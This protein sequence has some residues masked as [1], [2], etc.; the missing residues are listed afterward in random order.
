MRYRIETSIAISCI[1]IVTIACT[2]TRTP[3]ED[4]TCRPARP[5]VQGATP[6][7]P[8]AFATA[9]VT[10]E[11]AA[12]RT[13]LTGRIGRV[14][15]ASPSFHR[16]VE[17]G[18]ILTE[19]FAVDALDTDRWRVWQQDPETTTIDVRD[20]RLDITA[21]GP[22]GH[23]GL[24]GLTYTRLRDVVLVADMDIRS[25][26]PASHHIVLHLCGGGTPQGPDHWIEIVMADEGA[27]A[28]FS[29]A[30]A[31]PHE[32]PGPAWDT[33]VILPHPEHHGFLARITFDASQSTATLEVS[34]GARWYA[35]GD[36]VEI[37]FRVIHTEVKVH[38]Y[39]DPGDGSSPGVSAAWF[40][41]VRIYPRPDRHAIG[42]RL[43]RPDGTPLTPEWPPRFRDPA[44][45]EER[46]VGDL[47][48]QLLMEDGATVIA[49]SRSD[50]F[51]F[52][53]LPLR[54]AVWDVY[55]V[56]ARI[57]VLLDGVALTDAEIPR[58]G[59]D[60]LYPDDLYEIVV[61][62]P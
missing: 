35:I 39:R 50:S 16:L 38:R 33:A 55:P 13:Q 27:T 18:A 8:P 61:R 26:G 43:V 49:E 20:G 37:T 5:M 4:D 1:G 45:G 40:D 48:V 54:N 34:D 7:T 60:G 9:R 44:T 30:A 52:Y 62:T 12:P 6:I 36:P 57:R 58:R 17:R 41:N 2:E 24:F 3:F 46:T 56:R 21:S 19:D 28:R 15:P 10:I 51:G 29:A 11:T 22:V 32:L 25:D 23:D 14:S 31:L 42:V 59:I 53:L 47:V